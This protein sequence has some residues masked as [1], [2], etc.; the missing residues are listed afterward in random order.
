MDEQPVF[1]AETGL[2]VSTIGTSHAIS[3]P[4]A[5]PLRVPAG[6]ALVLDR[7]LWHS[8]SPNFGPQTRKVSWMGFAYRWLRPRDEMSVQHLQVRVDPIRRQ[9]LGLGSSANSTYDP[10]NEDVPLRQW[11]QKHF[12]DDARW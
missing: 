10:P 7:R 1:D 4:G 8:R 11:L 12:S 3:P 5:V 9:L 6:A 2:H